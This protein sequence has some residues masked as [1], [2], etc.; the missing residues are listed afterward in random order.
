M[1]LICGRR[2][3]LWVTNAHITSSLPLVTL[4]SF[5]HLTQ[6]LTHLLTH[7]FIQSSI[8]SLSSLT[9]TLA[10]THSLIHQPKTLPIMQPKLIV[11][12]HS[13]TRVW[14]SIRLGVQEKGN[15][16][17]RYP[18]H[19]M[20]ANDRKG[21]VVASY[22]YCVLKSRLWSVTCSRGHLGEHLQLP[23]LNSR[24]LEINFWK[25][26]NRYCQVLP[27][28]VSDSNPPFFSSNKSASPSISFSTKSF[29]TFS[30]NPGFFNRSSTSSTLRG[31]EDHG[32]RVVT[33]KRVASSR[34][35][36]WDTLVVYVEKRK[37][38]HVST[39]LTMQNT[40]K[41]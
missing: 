11:A 37:R 12:T 10:N 5:T 41:S 9:C 28:Q 36:Q 29:T 21:T 17:F 19:L 35:C 14:G 31:R 38:V 40:H 26:W 30:L 20:Q 1:W 16:S 6:L 33:H 39:M 34:T 13:A 22:E 2:R 8:H 24:S 7:P 32:P 23:S 3:A 27:I 15:L 25:L 18:L 4:Y